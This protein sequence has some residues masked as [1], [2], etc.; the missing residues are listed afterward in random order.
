VPAQ[1]AA[2]PS[3]PLGS[4][5]VDVTFDASVPE[6]LVLGDYY[7]ILR[8]INDTPYGN[9]SIPVTMTVVAPQYGVALA[10]NAAQS[11]DPGTIVTYT[12]QVTNEGNGPL[13]NFNLSVDGNAWVVSWD[14]IS[15]GPLASGETAVVQ[16]SVHVP[17]N[18]LAG[19]NDAVQVTAVSQGDPSKS[20]SVT[21][22]TTTNAVYDVQASPANLSREGPIGTTVV[23]NIDLDN[24]GNASDT[25]TVTVSGGAWTVSAPAVVGPVTVGGSTLVVVVVTIPDSVS[26][27]DTNTATLTFTSQGDPTVQSQV[28]IT[29]VATRR[30][31][32]LPFIHK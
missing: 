12:L 15:V 21:L 18:A 32:Y 6:V 16:V 22:T 14:P 31:V 26:A 11:G 7:A 29:T 24:L 4:Q 23:F 5:V 9:F 3:A 25:F 2:L 8:V 19:D 27:G 17:A 1:V 10:S 20:Q 30:G 28:Q 13:D